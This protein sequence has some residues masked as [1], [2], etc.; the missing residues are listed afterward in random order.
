[1]P[2]IVDREKIRHEI[3]RAFEACI[4]DK[5][6][7]NISLRDIA[8]KAHMTHPKL[9]NYFAGKDDIIL[10]YCEHIKLYR[11]EQCEKWFDMHDPKEYASP[12]DYMNA[13]MQHV[14]E[15]G[16]CAG[17]PKAAVQTYVLAKYNQDI[18][19]F[20]KEEFA[21]WRETME[22]C[23]KRVYG[24]AVG[25]AEAEAMMVLITGAFVCNYT[26]ALTGQITQ[27]ILSQFLNLNEVG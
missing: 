19:D 14:M 22:K 21:V 20:L 17:A 13:F 24:S 12:L 16:S 7:S 6:I 26:G 11:A 3:L 9:L 4:E 2:K 18:Q 27:N 15:N 25:S 5:P 10:A 8:A 1:M 23:L